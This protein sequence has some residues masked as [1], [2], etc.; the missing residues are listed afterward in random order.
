MRGEKGK[1]GGVEREVWKIRLAVA[2]CFILTGATG[3]M[4]EVVWTR[5]LG[6]L[7]GNTVYAV[8]IVLAAFMAGLALGSFAAGRLVDQRGFRLRDYAFLVG[9]V[10]F[11]ALAVPSLLKLAEGGY[12]A[13]HRTFHLS[14]FSF[15]LVQFTLTF[16]LLLL[17]TTLMGATL[18]LLSK[19]FVDDLKRLSRRMGSLYAL[20]T[21]GAMGGTFTTGFF[22]LPWMGVTDTVRIGATL[23]IGVAA[24]VLTFE[25]KL[26]MLEAG[27]RLLDGGSSSHQPS[28]S[29]P[30][31]LLPRTTRVLLL[32]FALSGGTAMVYEI[33]WTRA[34]SLVL[35]SSTYAFTVMLT[36]FLLGLALGSLL[37]ARW[38][39]ERRPFPSTF[40]VLELFIG[41]FGIATIP[42]FERLPEAFLWTFRL[43]PGSFLWVELIQFSIASVVM[44]APTLLFG[45]TFPCIVQL[46]TSSLNAL[47]LKVGTLYAANT[48][49]AI[50][51]S[52][53][54]GFLLL[55][56]MG[57]QRTLLLAA[58]GNILIGLIALYLPQ[59][60]KRGWLRVAV[61][62]VAVMGLLVP[63]LLPAWD[64][65]VMSSGVAIYGR[66]FLPTL[67]KMSLKDQMRGRILYYQ[68]G[69][70]AT[71][72]VHQAGKE[73]FLKTNGKTDASNGVDMATQLLLGHLP[74][75]LHREPQDVLV[76]GLGSGVTVGAVAA[77]P[78]KRIDVV[79]IE[80]AVVEASIFFAKENRNALQDPRVN[81][82]IAD[83]RQFILA[84]DRRYD[85]ITSEP[86]NPWIS[87]VANLF[88]L[89]FYRLAKARLNVGGIYCQWVQG[90]DL[91]PEDLKM[92]IKTFQAIFP[93]T[94]IWQTLPGDYLLIATDDPLILD[95][96]LLRERFQKLPDLR[97]DLRGIG[98]ASPVTLLATFVLGQEDVARFAEDAWLHTDDRPLL[99]FSAPKSLYAYTV[100]LNAR[101]LWQAQKRDLPPLLG[102]GEETLRSASFRYELGKALAEKGLLVQAEAQLTKALASDPRH[103]PSLLERGRI[104]RRLGFPL[105]ALQDLQAA[106][107]VTP[108]ASAYYE[109]GLLYQ[110]QQLPALAE[111]NFRR[112]IAQDPSPKFQRAL[113]DFLR[114][115]GRHAEAAEVYRKAVQ[116]GEG[117]QGLFD[118]L[119]EALVKVGRA[120]EVLQVSKQ[121]RARFSDDS[122]FQFHLGMAYRALE[123][124]HEAAEAFQR[125]L[126]SNP[127][128]FEAAF[129]LGRAYEA[130]GRREE[131][132]RALKQALKIRPE[133]VE[134][135]TLLETLTAD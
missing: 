88:S 108:R 94:T 76:I 134:A 35:G 31:A 33:A 27:S 49:G 90:Y 55:P 72:S 47:G 66:S 116:G 18:P 53:L 34:L 60:T 105:R 5:L 128:S 81:L 25:K 115:A 48:L 89:D 127:L 86:S 96:A 56:G 46:L 131:A 61:T 52:F 84:A 12:L 39:G 41:F 87:G 28:A 73:I 100:G 20:N 38:W 22:L 118:R 50:L 64:P 93:H 57:A 122:F 125:A 58:G 130:L 104:L 21:F 29:H 63:F 1:S 59:E 95:F 129:E 16:L 10:G 24:L 126:A 42:L 78:V 3:L 123:K 121:V 97:E 120:E 62:G 74:L 40:G 17:P 65:Q 2:F 133:S 77:H 67:G 71:I 7:F 43:F 69:L 124:V 113:G 82:H 109:L 117:D 106:L 119:G 8:T 103:V 9:G 36:T 102:I 13:L 79:E 44:I 80:P 135:S 75:L 23:N 15:H 14:S 91:Y 30:P 4:Y 92:I 99:E 68:E 45:M 32:G 98:V 85:V 37:F 83:A 54:A 107:K 26:A 6:L 101:L 112:A 111:E 51:G 110:S 70:N 19:F 11:Y 114:E 132:A